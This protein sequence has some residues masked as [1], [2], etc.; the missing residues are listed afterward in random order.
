MSEDKLMSPEGIA[1]TLPLNHPVAPV[2]DAVGS[3]TLHWEEDVVGK[4]DG[5]TNRFGRRR[6]VGFSKIN[7]ED[8][9]T[10]IGAVM[11]LGLA[12]AGSQNEQA[13]SS[14]ANIQ[15]HYGVSMLAVVATAEVSKT[16]HEKIRKY[17]DMT[18]LSLAYAGTGDVLKHLDEGETHQGPAVIGIALVAMAE[19]LR[20]EMSIRSFAESR[21]SEEKFLW[22]L[23]FS[24][25]PIQ[26]CLN[27]AAS[28]VE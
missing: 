25:Y 13:Q 9:S 1:F 24:A 10:R 2:A 6:E 11:G 12:Y 16:F 15:S 3:G 5:S 21:T 20:L 8:S 4:D 7:T 17:C 22:L 26:S 19:E 18:L 14:I 27:S 23:V 28:M